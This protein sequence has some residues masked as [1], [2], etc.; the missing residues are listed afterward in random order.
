M[1]SQCK[2]IEVDSF[3][4]IAFEPDDKGHTYYDVGN[5]RRQEER[6]TYDVE[7]NCVPVPV[8]LNFQ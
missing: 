5:I 4:P 7:K 8:N 6:E 3:V 1:G 2:E